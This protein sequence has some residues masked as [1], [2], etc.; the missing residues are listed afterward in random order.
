M[1]AARH[2]RGVALTNS[3]IAAT[4][5]AAGRLVE[6]GKGNDSF[7]PSII[8]IYHFITR[9]DRWDGALIR[10]FRQWLVSAI[11]KEHPQLAPLTKT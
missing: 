2:G 9:A 3:L 10:R 8:G 5:L 7:A 11:L 1:D 6:V 4:D